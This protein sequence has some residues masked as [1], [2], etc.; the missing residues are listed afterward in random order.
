MLR[1][2]EDHDRVSVVS[3]QI[4]SPTYTGDLARLAADMLR[5]DRYGVYHATNEGLCSW[6]EFALGGFRL[7]GKNVQVAPVLTQ[8]YPSRAK[9]PLNARLSKASLDAAG[10]ARLPS[11]QR[12]LETYLG[13]LGQLKMQGALGVK[14]AARWPNRIHLLQIT[15]ASS[16]TTTRRSWRYHRTDSPGDGAFK[17]YPLCGGQPIQRRHR[18]ADPGALPA[19]ADD[20]QS[21]EPRLRQGPQPSPA[22]SESDYHV[23]INPDIQLPEGAIEP[24]ISYLER[25]AEVAMVT[26]KI[27]NLDGTEQFLPKRRP[28]LRSSSAGEWVFAQVPRG[29]YPPARTAGPTDRD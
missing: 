12:A 28:R 3:D 7:S 29:V 4:G 15:G 26:P 1:L 5:T 18:G 14:G 17:F 25:H 16:P 20:P 10:F 8:D 24:L 22:L 19:G 6:R 11:W 13:N 21:E 23:I 27:L 9:R 2:A